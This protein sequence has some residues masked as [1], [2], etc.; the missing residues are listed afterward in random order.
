MVL[1]DIVGEACLLR[2]QV[3][4]TQGRTPRLCEN[5]APPNQENTDS[6]RVEAWVRNFLDSRL[7]WA[8]SLE[9]S[10]AQ[11]QQ[12][13]EVRLKTFKA[14]EAIKCVTANHNDLADLT[15]A[16]AYVSADVSVEKEA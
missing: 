8:V 13:H 1:L 16:F 6:H 14:S 3:Y 4:C 5:D 9:C 12:C 10:D 15:N 11:A 2:Y 7:V